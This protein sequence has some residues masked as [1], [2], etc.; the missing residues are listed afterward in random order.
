MPDHQATPPEAA[1]APARRPRLRQRLRTPQEARQWRRRAAGYALVGV[2]FVLVVNALVGEN[3]YLAT[4]QARREA[5]EIAAQIEQV[6]GENQ[7]LRDEIQRLN[8]DPAALEE[9]ARRDLRLGKP[10]ETMIIIKDG[11]KPQ[12]RTPK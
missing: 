1:S 11:S 2:S 4:A 10:G 5:A 6:V 9:A 8:V 3:G 7:R 12:G